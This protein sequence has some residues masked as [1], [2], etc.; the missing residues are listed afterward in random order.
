[1][2]EIVERV[3]PGFPLGGLSAFAGVFEMHAVPLRE[4]PNLLADFAPPDYPEAPALFA[5]V[6]KIQA[7]AGAYST[8]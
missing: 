4:I 6:R 3:V 1:M 5:L 8:Q 2:I 7:A